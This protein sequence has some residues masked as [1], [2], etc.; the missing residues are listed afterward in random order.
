MPSRIDI[1]GST[2][3]VSLLRIL[4]VLLIWTELG[5]RFRLVGSLGHEPLQW[6]ALL[7]WVLT[8]LMLLGIKARLSTGLVGLV[9][10]FAWQF[11]GL[12]QGDI[13]F[14]RHHVYTLAISSFWL[15]FTPC[16]GSFSWDRLRSV[17]RARA[18]GTPVPAEH[19]KLWGLWLLRLQ[20]AA[21]YLFAAWDKSD[22]WFAKHFEQAMRRHVLGGEF[23]SETSI[24]ML[25]VM[26]NTSVAL[27]YALPFT[28][29]WR[30][31][32]NLSL[33]VGIG[34]HFLIYWWLS[35]AT[36]SATMVALYLVF[37]DPDEVHAFIDELVASPTR[38]EAA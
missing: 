26:A 14:T 3:Q 12:A 15:A 1:E 21:M 17:R 6:I 2:R 5:N 22:P 29:L 18:E 4:L 25:D 11:Q 36:F 19:G 33:V 34:F 37:L 10:L 27:E 9:L 24:A 28:L 32:R 13:H 23:F 7:C 38:T 16:G 30:P 20:I 8:P 35:V 31:T